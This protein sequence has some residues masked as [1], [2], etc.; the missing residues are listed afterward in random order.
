MAYGWAF[1]LSMAALVIVSALFAA[2]VVLDRHH[3]NNVENTLKEA[4]LII[5]SLPQLKQLD[6]PYVPLAG[7]IIETRDHVNLIPVIQNFQKVLPDTPVYLFHGISNETKVKEAFGDTVYYIPI[8]ADTITIRQYNYLMTRPELWQSIKAEKVFVFQTDSTLFS[9][10][11]V[12]LDEYDAYDYVGAPW[13]RLYKYYVRNA[14]MFRGANKHVWSGNG[15][16]SLRRRSTME[17]VCTEFPYLS[18]PYAPE[19]VYYSNAMDRLT[20]PEAKLPTREEG[21]RLF[22]ESIESNELPLGC[23]K[24]LPKRFQDDITPEERAIIENY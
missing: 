17:R 15:G 5:E 20:E 12:S 10:S 1:A 6:K 19:D 9:K 11:K 13:S 18:I 2:Y 3:M 16:L 23:H 22:Y 7:L 4:P 24:Y 21:A 14:F 8:K